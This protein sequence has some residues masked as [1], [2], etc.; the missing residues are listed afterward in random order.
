MKT[1]RTVL[2]WMHLA[3]GS[4]A[5]IVVLIMC[6]TGVALTYEK[7][8]V[9]WADRGAWQAPPPV[10]DAHHL[11]PETLI[12]RVAAAQPA[13]PIGITLRS[14]PAA[15]ATVILEPN[16]ALLVD[17]YTGAIIGEP[18]SGLRTFFRT[19]TSWH[20]YLAREGESRA[21]GRMLTGYSNLLFLFIVLS[22]MYLWLPRVW[23]WLQFK[24]VL[25]FRGGLASKAR[26]FNWHNVIGIWSAVPLAIVVAGALPI[27][28]PWASNMV[29]RI[30]GDTPPA[31]A[32][33]AQQRPSDRPPVSDLATGVDAAW[34]TAQSHTPAWRTMTTRLGTAP[35]AP[36]VITV[37]EG[38]GGQPDKR[39][40]YTFDR[41]SG[42]LTRA[43][44]FSSLSA[45]R[46]LRSWL[47]FAH[48]GEIYGVTGQTIAGVAT[49]GGAVL[50][51]TGIA[52]ALRRLAAFVARRR[53]SPDRV[54]TH[55]RAA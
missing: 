23:T 7:Q 20:R 14:H 15:P 34:A 52:L 8:M 2:F 33:P 54:S 10:R 1:V 6:V 11:A 53:S 5:G 18:P 49:A 24:N 30:A 31:P 4:V 44:D 40:T 17:P 39:T 38:Y 47:R 46:R 27:S 50:V 42:M 32:A 25:W 12:A 36:V 21:S 29:Y 55:S 26:D 9:E 48:T 22:G 3:A 19:M 13:A 16:K 35:K 37:D 51:Y 28:F 45:G 43:E 41:A